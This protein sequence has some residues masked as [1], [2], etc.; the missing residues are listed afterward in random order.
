MKVNI[1]T[2]AYC[3]YCHAALQ[4]LDSLWVEYKNID[5]MNDEGYYEE[6][7]GITGSHTVPQ[8][9]AWEI[10]K[11]NFLW[12]YTEISSLYNRWELTKILEV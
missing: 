10:N 9:F 1:I 3:P 5:V 11:E 8:V 7:Q 12:W 4:L 6:V 2:K